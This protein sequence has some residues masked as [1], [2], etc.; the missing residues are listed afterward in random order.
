[1]TAAEQYRCSDYFYNEDVC[2]LGSLILD[3]DFGSIRYE[4]PNMVTIQIGNLDVGDKAEFY[5]MWNDNSEWEEGNMPLDI[6]EYSGGLTL[7]G[8]SSTITTNNTNPIH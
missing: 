2:L 3:L 7:S 5:Q 4:E 8:S 1:M 6:R